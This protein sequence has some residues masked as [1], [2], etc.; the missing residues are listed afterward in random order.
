[1][2]VYKR[3]SG[4]WAVRIDLYATST[5]ARRRRNLGTFTTKREAEAAERAALSARDRGTEIAAG[6]ATV[7][8]IFEGYLAQARSRIGTK[9]HERYRELTDKNV[10]PK[11]GA[12]QAARLR[13]T[14]LSALYAELLESGRANGK[15]GLSPRTVG[16]VHTLIHGALGWALRMELVSRNIADVVTAPKAVRREAKALTVEEAQQLIDGTRETRVGALFTFALA[17]GLRR[18]E[19]VA[20]RW[21]A[22]DE[23]TGT[24]AI[25]GSA[26]YALG[27]VTE[28][29]PKTGRGRTIALSPLAI[30]ALR[31]QKARQAQERLAAG[32]LYVVRGYVFAD[33]LGERLHPR[34]VTSA[35]RRAAKRLKISTTSFHSLRHTCASWM[36]GAG[37]DVR[38]AASVLGHASPTVTL[39]TY[40]HLIAGAQVSAVAAVEDRLRRTS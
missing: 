5:G 21:D 35:F 38:T 31:T 37:V 19:L 7:A 25:R 13:P 10:L 17:T 9:T 2:S 24:V 30:E 12:I 6:T 40:A 20:L 33:E 16:H 15:G 34:A 22:I 11:L 1:M 32:A 18:G 4:R 36:I 27:E 23:K 3:K 39:T 14:H 8:Q 29:E 28:K 26:S